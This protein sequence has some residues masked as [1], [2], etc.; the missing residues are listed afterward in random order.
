LF[1]TSDNDLVFDHV[2]MR[3]RWRALASDGELLSFPSYQLSARRP[4]RWQASLSTA[5]DYGI[6]LNIVLPAATTDVVSVFMAEDKLVPL[7]LTRPRG[8]RSTFSEADLFSLNVD[9][10]GPWTTRGPTFAATEDD[11]LAL[12]LADFTASRA[13]RLL[14]AADRD[15]SLISLY[16]SRAGPHRRGFRT[17]DADVV[18]LKISASHRRRRRWGRGW[19]TAANHQRILLDLAATRRASRRLLF[20]FVDYELAG[21]GV[22]V[23]VL[24]EKVGLAS[25]GPARQL[26]IQLVV[27]V[28]AA[29]AIAIKVALP[30]LVELGSGVAARHGERVLPVTCCCSGGG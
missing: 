6:F 2:S 4:W 28:V 23:V 21:A 13:A 27:A 1:P 12:H 14:A 7:D 9:L 10:A 26:D 29:V 20:T 18:A 8:R 30:L 3:G 17:A 24:A 5:E 19:A 16:L 25:T 15:I 22:A 11:V